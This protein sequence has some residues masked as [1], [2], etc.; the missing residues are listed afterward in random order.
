MDDKKILSEI[1]QV[2]LEETG[3]GVKEFCD[4]PELVR[5]LLRADKYLKDAAWRKNT[6]SG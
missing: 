3:E 5:K 6:H 1:G 4:L 2:V